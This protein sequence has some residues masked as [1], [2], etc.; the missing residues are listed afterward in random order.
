MVVI[1]MEKERGDGGGRREKGEALSPPRKQKENNLHKPKLG[2]HPT[3]RHFEIKSK[4]SISL[5]T[6]KLEGHS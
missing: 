6:I 2:T 1:I 4:N 3:V 5:K